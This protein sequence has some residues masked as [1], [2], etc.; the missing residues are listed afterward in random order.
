MIIF[1][2]KLYKTNFDLG[3]K[4]KKNLKLKLKNIVIIGELVDNLQKKNENKIK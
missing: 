2:R 4:T 3:F 1:F